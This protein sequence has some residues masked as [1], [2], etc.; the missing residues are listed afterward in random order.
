MNSKLAE[1]SKYIIE[2]FKRKVE[3]VLK[4]AMVGILQMNVTVDGRSTGTTT[5]NE[6]WK[7]T[8]LVRVI[9]ILVFSRGLDR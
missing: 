3:R 8:E 2:V 1:L 4:S 6:G 5:K 7:S 9:G